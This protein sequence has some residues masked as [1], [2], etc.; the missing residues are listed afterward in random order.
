M[1]AVVAR[2]IREYPDQWVAFEPVW[3]Q[4]RKE[5]AVV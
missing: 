1:L 4:Q 2:Y 5:N 3:P